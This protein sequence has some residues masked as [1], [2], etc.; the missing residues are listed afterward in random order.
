MIGVR[1]DILVVETFRAPTKKRYPPL[2]FSPPFNYQT[3]KL[4][5]RLKNKGGLINKKSY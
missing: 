2:F 3:V 1:I 5:G 4:K